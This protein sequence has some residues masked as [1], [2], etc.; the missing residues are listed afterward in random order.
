[1]DEA[2]NE[3]KKA[4]DSMLLSLNDII[5]PYQLAYVSPVKDCVLLDHNARFMTK[6]QM[7][8]LVNN[9]KE[10]GFL[11]Q[12]P[13]A[14]RFQDASAPKYRII[15]G[16]HRVKSA[17]KAELPHILLLFVDESE[18]SREKQIAVQLAHNAISGQDDLQTLLALYNEITTIELKEYSAVNV[19]DLQ[20]FE[21][22]KINAV[23]ESD[24][25]LNEMKL[26]F[27]DLNQERVEKV[28]EKLNTRLFEDKRDQVVFADF[29]TFVELMTR[30]KMRCN[31]KNS[32]TAFLKMIEI[33][34]NHLNETENDKA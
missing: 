6:E 11:S 8:Q 15:S 30:V 18:M 9:V 23:N 21:E 4:A 12:L 19:L 29:Y 26:Y 3:K 16:N 28:I 7:A 34:E 32:T 22:I 5:K 33:C 14:I 20:K 2:I 10:D 1:M 25:E 17:I 31:I 27:T 24:I 13:F